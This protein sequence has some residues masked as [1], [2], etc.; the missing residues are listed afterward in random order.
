M[1]DR[2]GLSEPQYEKSAEVK[3]KSLRKIYFVYGVFNSIKS[4]LNFTIPVNF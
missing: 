3:K 1:V 4:F 2:C